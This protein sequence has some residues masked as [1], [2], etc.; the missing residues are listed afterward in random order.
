MFCRI[1]L[2]LLLVACATS[3][4]KNFNKATVG[5]NKT[6]LLDKLGSPFMS[7]RKDGIDIWHYRYYEDNLKVYKEV[8]LKDNIVIYTGS[9]QN[10][11]PTDL[12]EE[13]NKELKKLAPKKGDFIDI[14]E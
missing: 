8:R 13:L 6:Q 1:F 2:L 9:L 12:K 11:K 10:K 3:G 7:D 5:M 4:L 14:V